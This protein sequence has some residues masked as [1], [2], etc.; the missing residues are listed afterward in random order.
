MFEQDETSLEDM[1]KDVPPEAGNLFYNILISDRADEICWRICLQSISF[2]HL[3]QPLR[4]HMQS[5]ITV[6]QLLKRST[7]DFG[8]N[9]DGFIRFELI[10]HFPF[11][12]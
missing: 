10:V 6:C 11:G 2:K 1:E 4:S 8:N 12:F 3:P 7:H 5:F 9:K